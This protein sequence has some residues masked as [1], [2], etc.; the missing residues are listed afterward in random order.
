M[1]SDAAKINELRKH[2]YKQRFV[3]EINYLSADIIAD[4]VDNI[5]TQRIDQLKTIISSMD[6]KEIDNITNM[7]NKIDKF[8]YRNTWYRLN[9]IYKLNKIKEYLNENI[10]DSDERTDI[11]EKLTEMVNNNKL[12]TKKTVDYDPDK[13]KINSI[14]VLEYNKKKK[15]FMLKKHIDEKKEKKKRSKKIKA[16]KKTVKKK[17]KKRSKK[18]KAVKKTVKKRS[19]KKSKKIKAVKKTVK[20]RSKKRS[21]KKK[22]KNKMKE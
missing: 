16:V 8:V 4:D 19:N 2:L 12:G 9:N 1:T 17:S 5:H 13:E 3:N 6:K 21:N 22:K 20:K 15:K 7:F 14:S 18:I 11:L 10:K